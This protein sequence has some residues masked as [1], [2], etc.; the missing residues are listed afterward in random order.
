MKR[1]SAIFL[2]ICITL[3][4]AS[5][6][7]DNVQGGTEC[8]HV[9]DDDY[10]YENLVPPTCKAPGS[11]NIV[12]HCTLCGEKVFSVTSHIPQENHVAAEPTINVIFKENCVDGGVYESRVS[13]KNCGTL[14]SS[15]I[16]YTECTKEHVMN[17]SGTVCIICMTP[18]THIGEHTVFGLLDGKT[19]ESYPYTLEDIHIPGDE[20]VKESIITLHTYKTIKKLGGFKDCINLESVVAERGLLKIEDSAFSGCRSLH[21]VELPNTVNSIGKGAFADCTALESIVIPEGVTVIR[22]STFAGCT[23]LKSV[24]LPS[25]LQVIED[26]AFLECTSLED[27]NIPTGVSTIGTFAF[28]LC[29]SLKNIVLPTALT[30]IANEAFYGCSSLPNIVI[31]GKVARVNDG[32]FAECTALQEVILSEGVCEIGEYAF[33][34]CTA[35]KSIVLPTTLSRIERAAISSGVLE[36]TFNDPENWFIQRT[37]SDIDV[38]YLSSDELADP[39]RAAE[40][41]FEGYFLIYRSK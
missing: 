16:H 36:I 20:H 33:K 26:G 9:V 32:A 7:A 31:P 27:I 12:R 41:I 24:T 1:L 17:E 5:C 29:T 19:I 2:F 13:C 3:V 10:S 25:T 4:L 11:Q 34:H 23:K 28:K 38:D 30:T 18:K 6:T 35:L 8:L 14:I 39:K 22:K 21:T 15:E 40:L 37:L